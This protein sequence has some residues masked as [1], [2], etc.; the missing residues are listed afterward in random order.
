MLPLFCVSGDVATAVL[1]HH[2]LSCLEFQP[3]KTEIRQTL[4]QI[5]I[6][7]DHAEVRRGLRDILADAFPE[8]RFSEADDGEEAISLL[9]NSEYAVLLLDINMPK[10]N[11]L[12]VLRDVR[13][14]YPRLPVIIVS[15]QPKEQ[16]AA[17][18]LDKGAAAYITKDKAPEELAPAILRVLGAGCNLTPKVAE[19]QIAQIEKTRQLQ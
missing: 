16:Y 17:R 15:G 18:C 6:A 7:D 10:R 5:L 9:A 4:M 2:R 1:P 19:K 13:C 14:N 8:A 3:A 11:G 12:D